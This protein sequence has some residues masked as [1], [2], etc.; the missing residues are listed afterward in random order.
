M[1]SQKSPTSYLA[2]SRTGDFDFGSAYLIDFQDEGATASPV[3]GLEL[4]ESIPDSALISQEAFNEW[5][6][7]VPQF[8]GLVSCGIEITTALVTNAFAIAKIAKIKSAIKAAGG[9][10]KFAEKAISAFK[11]AKKNG[12]PNKEALSI[13]ANEAAKVGGKEAVVAVLDFFSVNS[14]LKDC[15]GVDL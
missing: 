7:T 9:A 2:S 3:E 14:V 4:I 11:E 8:R 5:V 6:A 15:F 10:K 13:A 12:K 1:P